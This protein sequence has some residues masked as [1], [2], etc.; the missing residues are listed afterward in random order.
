M[1]DRADQRI[2]RLSAGEVQ[3]VALARAVA[4]ACGLLILDEPTSRLDE[5]SADLVASLITQAA[6]GGHTVICATHDPRLTEQA[7]ERVDLPMERSPDDAA[8]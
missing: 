4:T 1:A 5:H 6:R 7:D 2:H 8:L 3:R